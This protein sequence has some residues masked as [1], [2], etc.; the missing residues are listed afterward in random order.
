MAF[1]VKEAPRQFSRGRHWAERK[2]LPRVTRLMELEANLGSSEAN[3]GT[4]STHHK[5]CV[6]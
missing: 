3:S 2:W 4:F 6:F 5:H 1:L